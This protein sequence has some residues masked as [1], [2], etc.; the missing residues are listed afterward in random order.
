MVEKSVRYRS[1]ISGRE[2]SLT[3]VAKKAN[4]GMSESSR[5]T[6]KKN[7][8]GIFLDLHGVRHHEVDLLVENFV[9]SHQDECPLTIICGNSLRMIELVEE[10]LNRIDCSEVGRER[11]G[12]IVVRKV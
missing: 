5:I 3:V 9:Y 10:V 6:R 1:I 4:F 8:P 11:Y 12:L 7:Q 2:I